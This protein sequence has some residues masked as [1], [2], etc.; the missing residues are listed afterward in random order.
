[1]SLPLTNTT[2]IDNGA[3]VISREEIYIEAP[4]DTVWN[5]HVDVNSW[6]RWRADVDSAQLVS[7]FGVGSSFRWE[8]A[9]LH[10]TSTI[11]QM[12]PGSRTTWGGPADGID[13]VHVW[14]FGPHGSGVLVRTKESWNGDPAHADPPALRSALDESLRAWLR[15]LRDEAERHEVVTL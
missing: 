14:E 10:I 7:P 1:M 8:T 5:L 15:D 6:P 9:G 2:E 11:T 12:V 3:P 13:G 4:L